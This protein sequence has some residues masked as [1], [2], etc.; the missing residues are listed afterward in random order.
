MGVSWQSRLRALLATTAVT[1]KARDL[2]SG[3]LTR[4]T[5]RRCQLSLPKPPLRHPETLLI[6]YLHVKCKA[7]TL[8]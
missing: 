2:L 6:M 3:K 5:A 8:L 7:V 1:T 4:V